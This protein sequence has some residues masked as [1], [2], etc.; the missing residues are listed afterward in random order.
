MDHTGSLRYEISM[1]RCDGSVAD[2]SRIVGTCCGSSLHQWLARDCVY[3][4]VWL[5]DTGETNVAASYNGVAQAYGAGY[6][7]TFLALSTARCLLGCGWPYFAM[8]RLR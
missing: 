2:I 6:F 3:S 1:V 5:C 8:I 7:I 4:N